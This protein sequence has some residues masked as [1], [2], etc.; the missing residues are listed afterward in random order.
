M[1]IYYILYKNLI[2]GVFGA[3][4]NNIAHARIFLCFFRLQRTKNPRF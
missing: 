1:L 4:K 3:Q 2:G